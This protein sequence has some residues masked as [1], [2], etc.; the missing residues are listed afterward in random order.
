MEITCHRH[1]SMS[2]RTHS[3]RAVWS[4]ESCVPGRDTFFSA[5]PAAYLM[6]KVACATLPLTTTTCTMPAIPPGTTQL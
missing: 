2:T 4:P 5:V 3:R 6:V 1:E